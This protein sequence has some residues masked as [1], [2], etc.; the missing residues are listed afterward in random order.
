MSDSSPRLQASVTRRFGNQSTAGLF[1]ICVLAW[2]DVLCFGQRD[3]AL[4]VLWDFFFHSSCRD[5]DRP[6]C[7]SGA[8]SVTLNRI[9]SLLAA[10]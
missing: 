9:D 4:L 3:V 1:L 8:M 6:D 10:A 5:S 7:K 2:G